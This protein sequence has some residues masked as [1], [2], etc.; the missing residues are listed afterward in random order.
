MPFLCSIGIHNFNQ[1]TKPGGHTIFDG[2][3]DNGDVDQ[4]QYLHVKKC[5]RCEKIHSFV[6]EFFH[7]GLG[8]IEETRDATNDELMNFLNNDCD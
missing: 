4:S 2:L 7:Y 3:P 8:T 6:K 5:K 1:L